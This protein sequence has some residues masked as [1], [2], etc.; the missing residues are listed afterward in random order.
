MFRCPVVSIEPTELALDLDEL[1]VFGAR[2]DEPNAGASSTAGWEVEAIGLRVNP[3]Q[4][5]DEPLLNPRAGGPAP[6]FQQRRFSPF[7]DCAY[8]G[9][10]GQP[11]SHVK[12]SRVVRES[13]DGGLGKFR[14]L[15]CNL[16][17]SL[18]LG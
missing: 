15:C 14:N 18:D 8:I 9:R 4:L 17:E 16:L 5:R 12:V 1:N 6:L 3:R 7:R 2:L 10:A 11:I 13:V